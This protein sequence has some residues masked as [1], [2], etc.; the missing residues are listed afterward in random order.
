VCAPHPNRVY[1]A[2][3]VAEGE[4]LVAVAAHLV[5]KERAETVARGLGVR[6]AP[7]QNATAGDTSPAMNDVVRRHYV[8]LGGHWEEVKRLAVTVDSRVPTYV[9]VA[10]DANHCVDALAVPSDEVGPL[11]AEVLDPE[12]RTLARSRDGAGARSLVVCSL[13]AFAGTLA[14]RPHIGHGLTA[15]V[16]S[17]ADTDVYRD[18]AARPEVGWFAQGLPLEAARSSLEAL[19]ATGGYSAPAAAAAGVLSLSA[20][21]IVPVVLRSPEGGCS[22]IDVAAGAPLALFEARLMSGEGSLLAF[23]EAA[24]SAVLFGCAQGKANL[25]LE[26][27]GRP[28][29]FAMTVRPERWTDAAFERLPLAASRMLA[30]AALGPRRLFSG[31]ERSVRMMDLDGST[32]ASWNESVPEGKCARLVAGVQGDGAGVELRAFD[33][34]NGEIDRADGADAA[35]IRACAPASANRHVRF[36]IRASAGSLKAIVGERLD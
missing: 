11:D 7:E 13:V 22:R 1:V 23:A 12:G 30:K 2:G 25:E 32:T 3:H 14:I 4:G 35:M 33:D 36:E 6:D 9:A 17:R 8:E 34:T 15:V 24:N 20:R 29:P 21:A 28:G 18:I 27:H 16:L 26:A 19:L 5:T 31:K 10:V